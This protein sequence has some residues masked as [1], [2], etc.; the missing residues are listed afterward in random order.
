MNTAHRQLEQQIARSV[1]GADA[2]TDRNSKSFSLS[3]SR[4]RRLL[5]RDAIV[6]FMRWHRLLS[7]I[8]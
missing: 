3:L 7:R 1:R 2:N 5:E 8:A 4:T 6:L